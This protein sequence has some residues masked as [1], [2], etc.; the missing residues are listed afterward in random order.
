M[1]KCR[2]NDFWLENVP[3]LVCSTELVPL[4]GMSLASQLNAV[5]RLSLVIFIVLLLLDIKWAPLFLLLSILFIIIL[6]YIQKSQMDTFRAE[7][8]KMTETPV[9]SGDLPHGDLS[10]ARVKWIVN[11]ISDPRPGLVRSILNPEEAGRLC[12]DRRPLDYNPE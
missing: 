1:L 10:K 7:H 2:K 8:Y 9:K 12:H 4:Q 3:N 5:T 6:F 11:K